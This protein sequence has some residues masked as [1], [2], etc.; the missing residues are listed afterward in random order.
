MKTVFFH[1]VSF[2]IEK[3]IDSGRRKMLENA[4]IICATNRPRIRES[5]VNNVSASREALLQ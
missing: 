1:K 3:I 4:P 2:S 5:Q